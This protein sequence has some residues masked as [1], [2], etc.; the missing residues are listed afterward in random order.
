LI[1]TAFGLGL[2]FLLVYIGLNIFVAQLIS[3][4]TGVVFN[5]F[6]FT[7]HVF[8]GHKANIVAYVA[9]YGLNYLL[10]LGLLA[11]YHLMVRSPYLAGFLA[12]FTASVIN[13][14]MLKV[15]VFRR[16]GDARE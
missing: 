15:F 2:Y 1:N 6:M 16:P 11:G 14:V 12:T 7:T 5:Y 13:Y 4:F 3:H 9:S 8:K 10:G